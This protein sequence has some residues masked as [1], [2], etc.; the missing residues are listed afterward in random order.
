MRVVEFRATRFFEVASSEVPMSMSISFTNL[1]P[2]TKDS[3]F[4][5]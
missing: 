4:R 2:D 5:L 1:S 3:L